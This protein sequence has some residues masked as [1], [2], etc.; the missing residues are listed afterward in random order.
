MYSESVSDDLSD[1]IRW[2]CNVIYF[3]AMTHI[4]FVLLS[5]ILYRRDT[6]GSQ[7]SSQRIPDTSRIECIDEDNVFSIFVAYIE[8]YNN[9]I[10]DLLED[11][12]DAG[13]SGWVETVCLHI[14]GFVY[15]FM[16][17]VL[18]CLNA[19][20]IPQTLLIWTEKMYP[21]N[22]I[23]IWYTILYRC[24]QTFHSQTTADQNLAWR[25]P[26]QYVCTWVHR[27]W[28]EESRWCTGGE[29]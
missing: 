29:L 22:Y 19:L 14:C 28:S 5:S 24:W 7:D 21:C 1:S 27:G 20:K 13:P 10:Y 3:I 26:T 17:Y 8:I 25:C 11:L 2:W 9:Y 4:M 23:F 12:S 18:Q 6:S 15:I 16:I